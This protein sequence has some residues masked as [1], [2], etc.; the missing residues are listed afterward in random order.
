[1]KDVEELKRIYGELLKAVVAEDVFGKL[2][3]ENPE[4]QLIEVRD[5]YRNLT[6]TVFPD[7]YQDNSNAWEM[8][9]DARKILNLFREEAD[10]KIERGNYDYSRHG[11]ASTAEFVIKKADREYHVKKRPFT[12]GDLSTIHS[13]YRSN[14][15]QGAD[16]VI[17]KIAI[18]RSD[19]D[20]LRNEARIV[21]MLQAEP[22]NQS[23]H[24]PVLLDEFVTTDQKV[25]LV[26]K[27][28]DGYDVNSVHEEYENG[29]DPRHMA[30]I[31]NRAFSALGFAHSKGITNNN[32]E[33][34]HV[35]LRLR[36]HN[37]QI[38]G[39]GY[40]SFDPFHT[41][42]GFKAV[43]EDFSAP[44]VKEGKLPTPSSDMYSLGKLAIYVLGGNI[45]TNEMPESVDERFQRFIRFMVM[46]SPIQRAQDAWEMHGVLMTLRREIW[47]P[48]KFIPLEMKTK[49]I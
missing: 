18:D 41:G 12:E 6:K 48:D 1:M 23:K 16:S 44:E 46:E 33:P 24:F 37:A 36:D 42:E 3:S 27:R 13:G 11:T 29:I 26:F 38:L 8:A 2:Q 14:E 34:S 47:G 19:N 20:L 49:E 25:G 15:E 28:F 9:S 17:V 40:G 10:K 21:K 4:D 30:W 43:N 45:K 32:I 5:I 22:S 39:W 7:Y 31:L 35:M